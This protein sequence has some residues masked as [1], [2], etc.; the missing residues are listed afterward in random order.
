[1]RHVKPKQAQRTLDVSGCSVEG[2]PNFCVR[3]TPKKDTQGVSKEQVERRGSG[4]GQ[5]GSQ[6]GPHPPPPP[7]TTKMPVC[8]WRD[9]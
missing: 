2:G 7:A 3:G 8:R 9:K 4:R 1:M 6:T 5:E